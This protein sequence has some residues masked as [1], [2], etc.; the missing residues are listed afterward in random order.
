MLCREVP[1]VRPWGVGAT[2]WGFFPRGVWLGCLGVVSLLRGGVGRVWG[3]LLWFG[4]SRCV[5]RWIAG[6]A[7]EAGDGRLVPGSARF[8]AGPCRGGEKGEGPCRNIWA[9]VEVDR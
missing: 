9:Y 1:A 2:L 8:K 7:E 4:G 5:L 6:G 3:I